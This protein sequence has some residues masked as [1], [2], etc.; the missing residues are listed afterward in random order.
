LDST[1]ADLEFV[2][3]PPHTGNSIYSAMGCGLDG[4]I[5]IGTCYYHNGGA[6]LLG[7]H[8]DTG[9]MEDL[10][11]MQDVCNEHDPELIYQSKIHTQ[12]CVH[13]DGKVYFGTHSVE[14]DAEDDV[15]A[16]FPKG[17]LGGHWAVY[18]PA[19]KRFRDLGIPV[20][21]KVERTSEKLEYGQSLITMNIDRQRATLYAITHPQATF[22][23]YDIASGVTSNL[24][25]IGTMPARAMGVAS[26]GRVYTYND[27]NHILRYDPK[28]G[29]IETLPMLIPGATSG[30]EKANWAYSMTIDDTHTKIYGHGRGD[31]HLFELVCKP[32][33][34][35]VMNDLGLAIGEDREEPFDWVHAMTMGKD[36]WVYYATKLDNHLHLAGYNP[37]QRKRDDLGI[38]R[39]A[40][41][42]SKETPEFGIDGFAAATGSDGAIYIGGK[43]S[44]G[45]YLTE[46]N[47]GIM[48]YHP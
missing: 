8:P 14:R 10:G 42:A 28:K 26:D 4:I 6:H 15:R 37:A 7:Y 2:P 22:L 3:F 34:E 45:E 39:I 9:R 13:A 38:I 35:P 12:I 36:G 25:S 47:T 19:T 41:T 30:E 27:K 18:D 46:H 40:G 11:N 48:I 21:Q 33:E 16:K 43:T 1:Y 23:V 44:T 20:P 29:A 5:Y 24:G 31:G 32:G 17:Y